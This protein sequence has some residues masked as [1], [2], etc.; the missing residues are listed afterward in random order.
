V[1]IEIKSA[2]ATNDKE[3]LGPILCSE[4]QNDLIEKIQR[5]TADYFFSSFARTTDSFIHI[6]VYD[7]NIAG[8]IRVLFTVTTTT[9]TAVRRET[10]EQST[11]HVQPD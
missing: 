1:S 8:A 10:R 7:C 3:A 2:Y 5:S 4:P 6:Y 11:Y 9:T